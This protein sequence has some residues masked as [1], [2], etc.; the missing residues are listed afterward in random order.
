MWCSRCHTDVAAEIAENGQSL[1]CTSCGTEI[2]RFYTPSLH[3]NTR[4]AREL[5]ERWSHADL[6]DPQAA[7]NLE[8]LPAATPVSPTIPSDASHTIPAAAPEVVADSSETALPTGESASSVPSPFVEPAA[9]FELP[10]GEGSSSRRSKPE[11]S[12][13]K[14]R[15]VWRV[16]AAHNITQPV[17][18]I[19]PPVPPR[20]PHFSAIVGDDQPATTSHETPRHPEPL[21]PL[22][23]TSQP[24]IAQDSGRGVSGPVLRDSLDPIEPPFHPSVLPPPLPITSQAL[25]TSENRTVV[26]GPHDLRLDPPHTGLSGPH[27]DLQTFLKQD[28]RKPGR[29]EAIWG[30]VLAYLG[31]GL[32]TVGTTLVLWGWFGSQPTYAPTGWLVCTIG[33]MLLFLGVIT[34]ISGGMQQTSHE[35]TRRVEYL[36]DRMLRFEQSAEEVLRGPHFSTASTK[37]REPQPARTENETT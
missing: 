11:R 10:A 37:T 30:Q 29:A 33:Q 7:Q 32:I 31:V 25:D 27:F 6:L 2:Q 17:A 20:K 34:L 24:A 12:Q 19:L 13:P 5:L 23:A 4:S 36:G 8:A 28:E 16:D 26:R 1:L 35:V 14:P 3:P 15:T 9:P 22:K 18:P 21:S